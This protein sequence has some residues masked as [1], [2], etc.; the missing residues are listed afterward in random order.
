ML[1]YEKILL[2]E[3][4]PIVDRAYNVSRNREQRA[5][6]GHSMGGAESLYVGLNHLDRIAWIWAFSSTP[7]LWPAVESW[8]AAPNAAATAGGGGRE[9]RSHSTL[10]PW[11]ETFPNLDARANSQ[12]RMLWIVCGTSD[13]LIGS[14]DSSRIGSGRRNVQFTEQEV[15]DMG[16]VWPLWRQN[17]TEM[18]PKLFQPS[19]RSAR[20]QA[21]RAR[22]PVCPAGQG[23]TCMSMLLDLTRFRRGA[24]QV[25]RRFDPGDFGSGRG[26]LPGGGPRPP[27]S[28]GQEG[29]AEGSACG[30]LD[31]HPRAQ[32]RPL[33]RAVH[34]SG[35]HRAR[36]ALPAGDRT[37]PPGRPRNRGRRRR[38]CRTTRTT[39]ST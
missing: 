28:R 36:L 9:H 34:H 32:L 27:E 35:R 8:T 7:S 33:S 6:A 1:G 4:M 24:E 29:L 2:D 15:P 5:I 23:R 30:S 3:V 22:I 14:T 25:D 17:L 10:Q 19:S 39:R 16:H 20:G 13:G 37:G 18:V 26:G 31:G 11:R 38:A 12:I 21:S